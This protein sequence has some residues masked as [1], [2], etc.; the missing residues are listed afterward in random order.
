MGRGERARRSDA[1]QSRLGGVGSDDRDVPADGPSE[2]R[3]WPA[4]FG[5]EIQYSRPAGRDGAD[6]VL[7]II[8]E[9]VDPITPA[10]GLEDLPLA[11]LERCSKFGP[12]PGHHVL[13]K[14]TLAKL[15]R[16][17]ADGPDKKPRWTDPRHGALRF[18]AFGQSQMAHAMLFGQTSRGRPQIH[19]RY[20]F[21]MLQETQDRIPCKA[22]ELQPSH[23]V[24]VQQQAVSP[25]RLTLRSPRYPLR[26][27]HAS[28]RRRRVDV[29]LPAEGAAAPVNP[30]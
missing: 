15:R 26:H 11:R 23:E 25:A 14:E 5:S 2:T 28:H 29:L 1:L 19:H 7:P 8:V 30:G 27:V 13:S 9:L 22:L 18:S 6:M 21:C 10:V 20:L 4:N 3:S 24:V 16:Q 12:T 17:G